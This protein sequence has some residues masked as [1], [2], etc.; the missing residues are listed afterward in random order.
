M[1]KMNFIDYG[2]INWFNSSKG[3]GVV[4]SVHNGEIF[5]HISN[6]IGNPKEGKYLTIGE[7]IKNPKKNRIEARMIKIW[8]DI[9]L[10]VEEIFQFWHNKKPLTF[11]DDIK[12]LFLNGKEDV[13][14]KII[15]SNKI[16]WESDSSFLVYLRSHA[17]YKAIRDFFFEIWEREEGKKYDLN[18]RCALDLGREVEQ[19]EKAISLDI[20]WIYEDEFIRDFKNKYYSKDEISKL[21]LERI[22]VIDD[23]SYRRGLK[24]LI[25][26][27]A[28]NELIQLEFEIKYFDLSCDKSFIKEIR[29]LIVNRRSSIVFGNLIVE[30]YP[31]EK[32][33]YRIWSSNEIIEVDD[34]L[35]WLVSNGSL[36][37]VNQILSKYK[38][39]EI[40]KNDFI[41]FILSV[42]FLNR[43]DQL[44]YKQLVGNFMYHVLINMNESLFNKRVKWFFQN[45]YV[46][47][48]CNAIIN[49]N[50]KYWL[51][52]QDFIQFILNDYSGLG[53]NK[54]HFIFDVCM[55][56]K[57][58][59]FTE[60]VKWLFQHGTFL[61]MK[62]VLISKYDYTSDS[63]DVIYKH[64]HPES[65]INYYC[66]IAN[67]NDWSDSFKNEY[68]NNKTKRVYRAFAK[69]FAN[70]I[71][72]LYK[73]PVLKKSFRKET[74]SATDLAN[75]VFCPASYSINQTYHINIDEEE[76]IFIGT[77]EH[78][79]QHL[80]TLS[81]RMKTGN[82]KFDSY[83]ADATKFNVEIKR[84]LNAKCISEGHNEI[85]PII[86]YS[87]QKKL[88]G[89][90]DYIFQDDLGNFAVEE[91]FTFKDYDKITGLYE[92]HKMQALVYLYGLDEFKFDE[93]YVLYWFIT[94]SESR[95]SKSGEIEVV[96]YRLFKITKTSENRNS[97][98]SVFNELENI[99][100][101]VAYTFPANRINYNKCI[102]C[103]YFPYCEYKKG[104]KSVIKLPDVAS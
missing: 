54:L 78:E 62:K 36:N 83:T 7:F 72:G 42:N 33:L 48:W 3:F 85:N 51:E 35:R 91:K 59:L 27:N 56:K 32:F 80:K 68:L 5:I 71:D 47:E 55:N 76:N 64:L 50:R 58:T 65:D 20:E 12:W 15:Y 66:E 73:K 57:E 34:N 52:N 63:I 87:K 4:N 14:S 9:E 77:Q 10:L 11:N 29:E 41:D 69:L 19:F 43:N 30:E 23:T 45:I 25:F 13:I 60:C 17:S 102:R 1:S 101:R 86:Y 16:N 70:E 90:P 96:N 44:K 6:I 81:K 26:C 79:K 103:N 74:H 46:E 98:I 40:E 100:N 22:K 28:P 8:D 99:Q 89:I 75:F 94:K 21:I 24:W 97:L 2:I 93:V 53:L 88:S 104:R 92:N 18:L 31:F 49:K 95:V 84:I 37:T 38:P 61:M 39:Y 82:Y 67:S